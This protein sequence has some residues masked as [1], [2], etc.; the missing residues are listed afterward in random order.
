MRSI[1]HQDSAG[2]PGRSSRIEQHG[3]K[4]E[5]VRTPRLSEPYRPTNFLHQSVGRA[6]RYADPAAA[7]KDAHG[8]EAN[9]F[10]SLSIR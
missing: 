4:V 9:R 8:P 5:Q 2:E 1:H 10:L 7:P 6:A 3:V